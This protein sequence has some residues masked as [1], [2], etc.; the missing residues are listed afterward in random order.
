MP[1]TIAT[2]IAVVAVLEIK[3][4]TTPET[5]ATASIIR[6]GRSP[7]IGSASTANASRRSSR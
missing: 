6:S 5:M 3:P 4:L 7:T 2:I 1:A